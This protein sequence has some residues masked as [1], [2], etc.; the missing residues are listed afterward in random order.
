M[1]TYN[2]GNPVGS[3]DVRDLYDNA[4]NLDNFSNGPLDAY[5]DRFGVPRQSLQGIRNASQYVELGP[6]AAGLNFTSRNQVFSYGGE[7]YAPGPAI[8]LPYTTTGAGAGEIANFRSVGDAVLRSDL[9]AS[10]GASLVGYGAGTVAGAL[11][12]LAS[13]TVY[14]TANGL[15]QA[16]ELS[17]A[18]NSGKSVVLRG[19]IL[20]AS[21]VTSLADTCVLASNGASVKYIGAAGA[22]H[23]LKFQP[24]HALIVGGAL[25]IDCDNKAGI[26]LNCRAL[27]TAKLLSVD[28]VTSINCFQSAPSTGGAHGIHIVNDTTGQ[29]DIV[30]VTR[31]V[32]SSVSR[33]T[34]DIAGA[35]CSGIT[36]VDG[37][38]TIITGNRVSNVLTG[39]GTVDA[40]GIKVFSDLVGASYQ[41]SNS[42]IKS[43]TITDCAGRLVKLQTRGKAVV[44]DN[45]L[46]ITNIAL[47][48]AWRGIDSQTADTDI[49]NNKFYFTGAW[50]GGSDLA[51]IQTNV[52]DAV[53]FL[54]QSSN[55]NVF[56]NTINVKIGATL[57]TSGRAFMVLLNNLATA[58]ATVTVDLAENWITYEGGL[59]ST[60]KACAIAFT[61]R[62]PDT[63]AAGATAVVKVR[64]NQV[65]ATNFMERMQG[66]ANT[67]LTTK[68]VLFQISENKLLSEDV[69][70]V[71]PWVTGD[72]FTSNLL[73]YGNA[74]G[75]RGGEVVA[76]FDFSRIKPGSEFNIGGG[77]SSGYTNAPA[78]YTFGEL[79]HSGAFIEIDSGAYI[80]K[81]GYSPAP[82]AAITWTVYTL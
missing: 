59:N 14:V 21:P 72:R 31:C 48:T 19:D 71:L 8:T 20:V 13:R 9:A 51:V 36:A 22:T 30:S 11:D 77:A 74:V 45:L 25:T 81:S 1:T 54:G 32:V 7:F 12:A 65:S 15:D 70:P 67:D 53:D 50:S 43:N 82:G 41:R 55:H 56:G 75:R 68:L 73:V 58:A 62:A 49:R 2:T 63:W 78:N 76:P 35:V 47:I 6:Y 5:P 10:T 18:L 61:V 24:G 33:S 60:T 17:A 69:I 23:V 16:A 38:T 4:E 34:G 46:T 80:T 79:R 39:N 37:L 28:G 42:L 44:E 64:G 40:D 29:P 27:P 66:G 57:L 3:V 52:Q 26:G